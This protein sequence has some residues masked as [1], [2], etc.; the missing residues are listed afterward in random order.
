ME[1]DWVVSSVLPLSVTM[2]SFVRSQLVRPTFL[3]SVRSKILL[4]LS[5][6]Q[7]DVER[8]RF[9]ARMRRR[10]I[11]LSVSVFFFELDIV[12]AGC[13]CKE[14]GKRFAVKHIYVY[15]LTDDFSDVMVLFIR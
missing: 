9:R 13:G 2:E 4:M 8:R 15:C 11:G 7:I 12:Y 14:K 10:V 5:K 1:F 3:H 6:R